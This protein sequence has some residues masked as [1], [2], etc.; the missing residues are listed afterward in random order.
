[1]RR[2]VKE[3]KACNEYM[4]VNAIRPYEFLIVTPLEEHLHAIAQCYNEAQLADHILQ[5]TLLVRR[6]G[7][8]N[9]IRSVVCQVKFCEYFCSFRSSD[10][11]FLLILNAPCMNDTHTHTHTYTFEQ[12]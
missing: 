9:P 6:L 8:Q 2:W 10:C 12:I 4:R 11:S 1:M 3:I 5:L 7:N